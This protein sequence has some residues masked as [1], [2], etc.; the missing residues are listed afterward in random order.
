MGIITQTNEQYYVGSESFAWQG[1]SSSLTFSFDENIK[2]SQP[3]GHL[4]TI[5]ITNLTQEECG[6]WTSSYLFA[7]NP[8]NTF[9]NLNN[10]VLEIHDPTNPTN[11]WEEFNG[12]TYNGVAI[13]GITGNTYFT[14]SNNVISFLYSYSVT[15]LF[16]TAATDPIPTGWHIRA[17]LKELH[18]GNYAYISIDDIINNVN[19]NIY[20]KKN[21]SSGWVIFYLF[22]FYYYIFF[23]EIFT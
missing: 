18:Y 3:L 14:L 22:F 8:L 4:P 12:S 1:T 17:R 20:C 13:P 7:N 2:L 19:I 11:P 5:T 6:S 23:M 16:N 15:S 10:F 21:P 9:Y